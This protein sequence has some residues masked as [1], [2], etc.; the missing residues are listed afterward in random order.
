MKGEKMISGRLLVLIVACGFAGQTVGGTD[1][2]KFWE[3]LSSFDSTVLQAALKLKWIDSNNH[4]RT[5]RETLCYLK[6]VDKVIVNIDPNLGT[7]LRDDV[8]KTSVELRLR[9]NG[10]P[11]H[12]SPD[13]P[14]EMMAFMR[15]H[16]GSMFDMPSLSLSIDSIQFG[17]TDAL[18]AFVTL[19]QRQ[20]ADLLSADAPRFALVTTW[21]ES[22]MLTG[23]LDAVARGCRE[24]INDLVDEYCND[25]LAAHADQEK[26]Q[27]PLPSRSD[28]TEGKK[29]GSD[30]DL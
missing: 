24:A 9:G 25:W 21:K 1:E 8:V 20:Q 15:S 12:E 6:G 17:K 30:C 4:V 7:A 11:L 2:T 10:I 19:C 14:N 3:T 5:Q 27:P 23:G 28:H 29:K 16:P 13:A 26:A 22:H 18:A